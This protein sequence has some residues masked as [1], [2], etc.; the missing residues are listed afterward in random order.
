[1][2]LKLGEEDEDDTLEEDEVELDELI[3][4]ESLA[5]RNIIDLSAPQLIMYNCFSRL[6]KQKRTAVIEAE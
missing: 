2:V 3:G 5:V 4:K 1:V 6:L